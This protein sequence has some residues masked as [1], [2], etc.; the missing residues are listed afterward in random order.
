MTQLNTPLARRLRSYRAAVESTVATILANWPDNEARAAY[1]ARQSD[2]RAHRP[3][4][5]HYGGVWQDKE[6]MG[7]FASAD[8]RAYYC[9]NWPDGLRLVG[10]ADEVGGRESRRVDHSGWYTDS[11]FQQETL[12]GYVLQLPARNGKP[13]YI[14][15]LAHSDSEGVT[16]YPL[17][18]LDDPLDAAARA[19]HIAEREAETERGYND[20]WQA[21]SQ[22]A[23][24]DEELGSERRETLTAIAGLPRDSA[25]RRK[26]LED[27]QEE[28]ERIRGEIATLEESGQYEPDAFKEGRGG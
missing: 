20:A 17:Q 10:R 2:W 16:L 6:R 24:L 18:M 25:A 1:I 9:D 27:Y 5:R 4:P 8:D 7:R 3:S 12:S 13:R 15:G 22:A 21:G 19:D 11:T 23:A 14:P 28:R 26:L